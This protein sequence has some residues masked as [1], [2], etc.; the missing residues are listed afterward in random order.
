MSRLERIV[1]TYCGADIEF[2]PDSKTASCR[3]CNS[4][5]HFKEEK[6]PALILALNNAAGFFSKHDFDAAKVHYG[7][8]LKEYPNDA[9]AAWGHAISTYGIVYENDERTGRRIP[10][11]SRIIDQ[12]ILDNPS[13]LS[14]IAN[15]AEE[16]RDIYKE[17][18]A[19]IDRVQ[20]KIKRAME[21]EEDFD[22][23]ISFKA[24]DENDIVTEDSVIARNIY[25]ELTKKGIKTF[26]SEV[27]LDGR[28]GDEYEPIIYRALYSCKFFILVATKKEYV[29]APWVKNEWSRFR[30]R[31]KDEGLSGSCA[32]VYKN[33]S[34]YILDK[35]FQTQGINLEKHPFDYAQLVAYNLSGKFGLNSREKEL[36]QRIKELEEQN[37]KAAASAPVRTNSSLTEIHKAEKA[38]TKA[39]A[40]QN[41]EEEH[42]KPAEAY[43]KNTEIENDVQ[44]LGD[45]DIAEIPEIANT[46]LLDDASMVTIDA[47]LYDSDNKMVASWNE[48]VHSYGMD[49]SKNYY[50]SD[51][52]TSPSSP[53]YVLTKKT[54]LSSGVKIVIP[55]SVTRIGSSAFY[56]CRSLTSITIPDSVTSIG[57]YAFA[58]CTRLT[59]I[60]V[61]ENNQYYKS[62]DGNLY[63]KD[64][65]KLIQYAIGKT[66]KRFVIPSGVTG[67]GDYAFYLCNSLR[68][69]TIPDSVASIGSYAFAYCASLTSITIG[70]SV[71]SIGSY[72]FAY[73]ASL[74]S[75]TIGNSVT[76]IGDWAFYGCKKLT[77]ITIPDGVKSIG[78]CAFFSCESLTSIKIPSNVSKIGDEAFG[79]CKKLKIIVADPS[80]IKKWD[81]KW[82]PD[83]LKVYS[84]GVR[85]LKNIFGVHK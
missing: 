85:L 34:P 30:D 15:C 40:E 82:N 10:T 66:A 46:T 22:V 24:K 5:F 9:E 75:I 42:L 44:S 49:V 33:F 70:N 18:A 65:K 73:C 57:S 38:R 77:S 48:L 71:T 54:K 11:C 39:E 12:S 59:S 61:D 55:D 74:T 62:I 14:A 4:K 13:Y 68:S 27:T 36:E 29:E 64:G 52:K 32:A 43:V 7:S 26:F 50:Y 3:Y 23:F 51:Y 1:C 41:N 81:K 79:N 72:A 6:G 25:E 58:Y 37:A 47:G 56:D 84:G 45:L 63:S 20:K 78:S 80:N 8:I 69:M 21:N 31:V 17:G 2:S 67:I 76:S 35:V 60:E 83:N 53:Y 28:F 16:Q 19:F